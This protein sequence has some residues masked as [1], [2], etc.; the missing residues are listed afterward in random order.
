VRELVKVNLSSLPCLPSKFY[1][2]PT[3]EVA[4]DLLG[5]ILIACENPHF[6]LNDPRSKSVAGRIVET[7]AYGGDDPASH[8]CRGETPRCSIMFG[9]PGVAYVYFIYGMYEML[10]FVTEPVGAPG[11]V[12]IRALEP[13]WGESLMM[14]RRG[15]V[16]RS[17]NRDHRLRLNLTSGP[18]KLCR[19]F[20]IQMSHNGQSLQGPTLFVCDDG[21]R[22]PSIVKSPRVGIRLATE[23]LW[24]FY[25][26]QNEFVSRAP[27]NA[28]SVQ[29]F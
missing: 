26:R 21:Y 25:I 10:N 16:C 29:I 17:R 24:R 19:A 15:S 20:G 3:I 6:P 2:R 9:K 11:A 22:P 23:K 7:E 12:L 18:G 5:K 8:S 1:Q 4:Q 27:Q 13:I 28:Q 14:K